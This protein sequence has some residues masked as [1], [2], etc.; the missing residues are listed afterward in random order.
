MIDQIL[1]IR[2]PDTSL[3]KNSR[4]GASQCT[5]LPLS[6][7]HLY[8]LRGCQRLRF[9]P[10]EPILFRYNVSS[11]YLEF[12]VKKMLAALIFGK[13][14]LSKGLS[15]RFHCRFVHIALH[16]FPQSHNEPLLLY[17]CALTYHVL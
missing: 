15:E 6:C 5:K 16:L 4:C 12:Q 17:T 9:C 8:I 2:T 3:N 1:S 7:G 10:S 11:C 13:F 14:L